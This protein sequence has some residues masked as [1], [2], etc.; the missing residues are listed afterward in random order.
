MKTNPIT[1]KA[2]RITPGPWKY[3]GK[4]SREVIAWDEDTPR[5]VAKILDAYWDGE[6][7]VNARAIEAVPE[8]IEALTDA[9]PWLGAICSTLTGHDQRNLEQV[10]RRVEAVLAKVHG[11][12]E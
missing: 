3:G 9:R 12:A 2:A 7:E 10:V 5:P 11:G 6:T 4:H 8:M 1:R